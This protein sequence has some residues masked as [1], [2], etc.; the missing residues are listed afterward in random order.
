MKPRIQTLARIAGLLLL[1]SFAAGG[2]G[3]AYVPM[4]LI[5]S[6]DPAATAHNIKESDLLF[7][8][9]FAGYFIEAICDI[10]LALLFVVLLRR[11]NRPVALLA[12]F[13][14][15]LS[16]ALYAVAELF[17]YAAP[18][19]ILSGAG[20][21]KVFTPEQINALAFLS[22]KF[23]GLAGAL[24]SGFYGVAWI[25][26]GWLMLLSGYLPKL[27]GLLMLIGGLA[28]TAR[29]FLLLLAPQYAS[30]YLLIAIAP[31]GVLL[32]LWLLVMGVNVPQ[33][34]AK[35]AASGVQ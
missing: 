9:S 7:R 29:T 13:F 10:A 32:A 28:F 3:E 5:V 35:T 24:V 2:F 30:D 25:L 21:L 11:V 17:Y 18:Q 23:F 19:L 6:G 20:Y 26:R 31:G 27:L 1:I 4:K 16:T 8:L 22:L 12:G 15:I 14:G 33:W 34:E